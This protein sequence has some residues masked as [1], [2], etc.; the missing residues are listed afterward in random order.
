M[1]GGWFAGIGMRVCTALFR[2][3]NQVSQSLHPLA[4]TGQAVRAWR[5]PL[6]LCKYKVAVFE[7]EMC[8]AHG[9]GQSQVP[10]AGRSGKGGA[11]QAGRGAAWAPGG[12]QAPPPLPAASLRRAAPRPQSG[13]WARLLVVR[14]GAV[15]GARGAAAAAGFTQC[16]SVCACGCWCAHHSVMGLVAHRAPEPGA[17]RCKLRP[18][19]RARCA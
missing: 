9:Y 6:S 14:D 19:R 18:L 1:G 4:S 2:V 3:H 17:T 15:R 5:N 16:V 10:A 13:R 8:C 7:F 11:A 12:I